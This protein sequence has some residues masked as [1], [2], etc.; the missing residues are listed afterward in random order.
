MIA[1]P[2]AWAAQSEVG[3]RI[4]VIETE[5]RIRFAV[6]GRTG[7]TR[8]RCDASPPEGQCPVSLQVEFAQPDLDGDFPPT[9]HT[10]QRSFRASRIAA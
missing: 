3:R 9:G 4:P 10:E 1:S 7:A 2:S 8:C 6:F 5:T